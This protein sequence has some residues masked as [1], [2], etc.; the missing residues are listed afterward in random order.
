MSLAATLREWLDDFV[1]DMQR[2]G[3]SER[4]RYCYRCDLL[5]FVKWVEEKGELK[6]P[7]DLTSGVLEQYQL[8]LMLRRCLNKKTVHPRRMTAGSRNRHLAELKSFFRFLKR[9]HRLLSNPSADLEPARERKRLPRAILSVPEVARLLEAVPKDSPTGLR[10]WAALE[11]LYG[12]GLRRREL[13]QLELG[14]L[15]L[16]EELVHILGK[17]DRER[18][19]PMGAAA[20]RALSR[21]LNEG[22]G[23][24]LKGRHPK[25][26]VS[27]WHGGPVSDRELLRSLREHAARAGLQKKLSF[28][29]F[30]HTCATHLLRGGADLRTIQELLGHSQLQTTALYTRV[31]IGDLRKA[32]Q[33]CHPR[34]QDRLPPSL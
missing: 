17:G 4:S 16:G 25:V 6:Q 5:L 7:G 33:E 29:Q 11:L 3:L 32:L 31:E 30:R 22:R 28:H 19:V 12:T 18:L 2:R 20:R 1:L 14:D 26:F 8:H 15:R 13:L 27:S 34:E 24:L 9:S 23:A 21:Y 10:D